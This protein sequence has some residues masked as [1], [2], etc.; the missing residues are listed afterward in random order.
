M[1]GWWSGEVKIAA[2]MDVVEDRRK[3]VGMD[4][5]RIG[6][7]GTHSKGCGM[8]DGIGC[9]ICKYGFGEREKGSVWYP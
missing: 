4:G 1:E 9:S 7:L 8:L 5:W 2:G 6:C 3:L